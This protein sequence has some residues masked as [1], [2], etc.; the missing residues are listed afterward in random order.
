MRPHHVAS[1]IV[2]AVLVPACAATPAPGDGG[3]GDARTIDANADVTSTSDACVPSCTGRVCGTDGCTGTCGPDCATGQ[4][5]D[6]TGHCVACVTQCGDR[7]CGGDGCGGSCGTCPTGQMCDAT[8]HCHAPPPPVCGCW[9]GECDNCYCGSAL[10][11]YAAA[12]NCSVPTAVS[13]PDA[14]LNCHGGTWTVGQQCPAGCHVNTDPNPDTCNAALPA[15]GCWAG[16]CDNCYCG[17]AINAYASAHSCSVPQASGHDGGLFSCHGGTFSLATNC[18]AGCHVNTTGPDQCDAAATG[19]GCWAGDCDSCYC[20]AAVNAYASSHGCNVPAASGHDGDLLGCHGGTWTVQ[21]QCPNGCGIASSG[22]DYCL[23]TGTPGSHN[24]Y[25]AW[26]SGHENCRGE[27]ESFFGCLFDHTDFNTLTTA[28]PRGRSL[29]YAGGAV[30]SGCALNPN[31]PNQCDWHCVWQC[32]EN[33]AHFA[34][35][36]GDV[37][38]YL[39]DGGCGGHNNWDQTIATPSG[40]VVVNLAET[41]DGGDRCVCQTAMGMHET[42]EASSDAGAADCCNGQFPAHMSFGA[43]NNCLP[44][45]DSCSPTCHQFGNGTCGGDG[46]FGWYHLTCPGGAS[47]SAVRVSPASN[48]WTPSGCMQ[49]ST[50]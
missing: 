2:L 4:Q 19:C 11:N 27:V 25:I 10:I 5:C 44:W 29:S 45:C 20:G 35:H 18:P 3:G 6:A 15:C 40:N 22:P 32:V 42:Y 38:L 43:G 48:E 49:L 37:M 14:L 12:H 31:P 24:L 23:G 39:H 17:S 46:T 30:V 8:S 13:N 21:T 28:F 47:Y 36:T 9:G 1:W 34:L 33:Q 26:Q 16:Q 41:G 50:H 7:N